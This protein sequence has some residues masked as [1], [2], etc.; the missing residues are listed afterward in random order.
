[1]SNK[2][3]FFVLYSKKLDGFQKICKHRLAASI[4]LRQVVEKQ[5][6]YF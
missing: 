4:K 5:L 3:L 1:M 2:F 6:A